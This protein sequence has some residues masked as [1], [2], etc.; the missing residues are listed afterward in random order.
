MLCKLHEPTVVLCF[1]FFFWYNCPIHLASSG[2]RQ[3]SNLICAHGCYNL[4]LYRH[5]W[6]YVIKVDA[7]LER[8]NEL[9]D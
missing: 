2:C 3:H 8:M 6:P 7:L 5:T 4:S 1:H 9:C